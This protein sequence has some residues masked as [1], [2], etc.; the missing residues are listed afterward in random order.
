MED[1]AAAV[2]TDDVRPLLHQLR[3]AFE[4]IPGW[5]T[6]ELEATVRG[7]AEREN[8]KLGKVAQPLRAA[9]TGQAA[10]PG[11]FDVLYALGRD[12]ALARIG[13]AA[14]GIHA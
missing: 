10:S 13:D 11:I 3:E 7:F 8:L 5:S 1:K 6:E 9:L 2:L 4:A 14:T 12:E